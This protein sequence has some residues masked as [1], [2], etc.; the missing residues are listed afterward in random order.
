MTYALSAPLQRAVYEALLG[1]TGLQALV[2]SHIYDG[3]LPLEDAA[4]PVD[5]VTLGSETVKDAGTVTT[6]GAIHDFTVVVHSAASG[7]KASK[8]IAGAICDVLLDTQLP[9]SRGQLVYLRFLKARAAVGSP[10]ARRSIQLN[11]RAFVEDTSS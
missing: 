5:Y 4:V 9:L 2:G 1:D 11:F 6:D 7:F 8:T 3:P 10:P